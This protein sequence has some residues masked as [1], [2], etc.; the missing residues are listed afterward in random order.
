MEETIQFML[1]EL[2][3]IMTS[4]LEYHEGLEYCEFYIEKYLTRHKSFKK[5]ILIGEFESLISRYP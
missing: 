4:G 2:D 3:E 1:T 5:D